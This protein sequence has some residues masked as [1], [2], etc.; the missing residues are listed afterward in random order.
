[1]DRMEPS[2]VPEEFLDRLE[3]ISASLH[4][5]P[6]SSRGS[7]QIFLGPGVPINLTRW[8]HISTHLGNQ[9]MSL[10]MRLFLQEAPIGRIPHQII[11][12]PFIDMAP[13]KTVSSLQ[14]RCKNW[15]FRDLYRQHIF[16]ISVY[17][18]YINKA[19]DEWNFPMSWSL[20]WTPNVWLGDYLGGPRTW[21]L[22]TQGKEKKAGV[23]NKLLFYVTIMN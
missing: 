23:F 13:S 9:P 1:M 5:P 3:I 2:S 14:A 7:R 17:F 6:A 10:T 18:P 19:L 11:T 20:I 16:M 15:I 4:L 22:Q 12:V 8:W 21:L